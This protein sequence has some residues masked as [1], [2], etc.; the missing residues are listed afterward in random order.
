MACPFL[1][2]GQSSDALIKKYPA[3]VLNRL[4]EVNSKVKLNDQRQLAIANYFRQQDSLAGLNKE[5][6]E[7]I[8]NLSTYYANNSANLSKVLT[9]AELM[10]YN[11]AIDPANSGMLGLM[12]YNREKMKLTTEQLR[13]AQELSQ[14]ILQKRADRTFNAEKFESEQVSKILDKD[15]KTILEDLIFKIQAEERTGLNWQKLRKLGLTNGLDSARTVEECVNYEYKKLSSGQAPDYPMVLYKLDSY[16]KRLPRSQFSAALNLRSEIQLEQS[17]ADSLLSYVVK[18]EKAKTVFKTKYP[19]A[20]FESLEQETST[21]KKILA[22]KQYLSFQRLKFTD[23]ARQLSSN[24][25]RKAEGYGLLKGVD[26]EKLSAELF[27]YELNVLIAYENAQLNNNQE[28][29]L[30]KRRLREN[31]PNLYSKIDDAAN[32]NPTKQTFRF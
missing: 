4:Y 3:A 8:G 19:F 23:R 22:P 16:L 29:A 12:V 10:E 15:Q 1:S 20:D 32:T 18:L 28:N 6:K 30:E 13:A 17:Q 11:F 9:F 5:K 25:V 7:A 24:N 21:L 31:K 26:A 27:E 14:T 2:F